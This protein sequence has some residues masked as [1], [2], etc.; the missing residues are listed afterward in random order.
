MTKKDY[1]K[2]ACLFAEARKY[3]RDWRD[4]TESGIS[5]YNEDNIHGLAT[6]YDFLLDKVETLLYMDNNHFSSDK[7]RNY[8][9]K[10]VASKT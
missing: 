1:I 2:F 5:N 10:E 3:I 6:M 7:F 4:I 8:I 9:D